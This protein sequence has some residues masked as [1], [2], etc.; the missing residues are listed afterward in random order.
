M[1]YQYIQISNP[2]NLIREASFLQS[3]NMAI[4]TE[5]QLVPMERERYCGVLSTKW[6]VYSTPNIQESSR[7]R[8]GKS[9]RQWMATVK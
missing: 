4:N 1:I 3:I 2:P 9:Q 5:T 8:G 6:D 7:E